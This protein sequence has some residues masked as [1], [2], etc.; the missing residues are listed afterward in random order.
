MRQPTLPTGKHF[1]SAVYFL[2][3]F[4]QQYARITFPS[5]IPNEAQQVPQLET[6]KTGWY[7]YILQCQITKD[8][9][10]LTE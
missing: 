8:E 5:D 6:P 4:T 7:I 3:F 9:L 1:Q 10:K 2:Y